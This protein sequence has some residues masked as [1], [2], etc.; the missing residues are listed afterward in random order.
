MGWVHSGDQGE[1]LEGL[2][3]CERGRARPPRL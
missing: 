1:H 2:V 3:V